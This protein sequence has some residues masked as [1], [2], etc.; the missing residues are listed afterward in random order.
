MTLVE[1]IPLSSALTGFFLGFMVL[2]AIFASRVWRKR[3]KA[4][5]QQSLPW[6]LGWT[7]GLSIAVLLVGI[8]TMMAGLFWHESRDRDGVLKSS[9]LSLITRPEG[10]SAISLTP[11][12]TVQK[13][14]VIAS[15]LT[16]EKAIEIDLLE[17]RRDRLVA[18]R[19]A[20]SKEA[21]IEEEIASQQMNALAEQFE[22]VSVSLSETSAMIAELVLQRGAIEQET[23]TLAA[24][25]DT[26]PAA[27][28]EGLLTVLDY[29]LAPAPEQV[30]DGTSEIAELDARIASLAAQREA[31]MTEVS[32]LAVQR[33]AQTEALV[34]SAKLSANT[35]S[36]TEEIADLAL[37]I[38][39]L[40][41]QIGVMQA[42]TIV[43]APHDGAILFR[44]DVPM[45]GPGNPLILALSQS[46]S[47]TTEAGTKNAISGFLACLT[48]PMNEIQ[49]L[50][51]SSEPVTFRVN[52]M[53]E[54]PF[55][56]ATYQHH[57][58][59]DG[60]AAAPLV[61]FAAAP[62]P[63]VIETLLRSGQPMSVSLVTVP[64][65]F[66]GP[67]FWTSLCLIA[68]A[69]G[70]FLL[71]GLVRVLVPAPE[72]QKD[73]QDQTST[74]QS[75]GKA[76]T[77]EIYELPRTYDP[78]PLRLTDR[79]QQKI[80]ALGNQFKV[81]LERGTLEPQLVASL[82]WM[83]D[84]YPQQAVEALTAV[85]GG[86]LVSLREALDL[87]ALEP[88]VARRARAIL[89]LV[90][91]ASLPEAYSK[92]VGLKEMPDPVLKPRLSATPKSPR[93]KV[94]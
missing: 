75:P 50:A 61:T 92:N 16:P 24:A 59:T 29:L 14:E 22:L 8:G 33:D 25:D 12:R 89:T 62:S 84:R 21:Q 82:E 73:E 76:A 74:Q 26:N 39:N 1:S 60:S 18:R 47:M 80:C 88:A 67:T 70:L 28:A 83:V 72:Q 53:V 90:R 5:K 36:R 48:L 77:T 65:P 30:E 41:A 3:N 57:E 6:L 44:N 40:T 54:T 86:S 4:Q 69:V 81:H 35:A 56:E 49:R 91:G 87:D 51:Q 85:L 93:P 45:L 7:R 27:Q 78:L 55:F 11:S 42:D 17:Q 52:G 71:Q 66:H 64:H 43:R 79:H 58:M 63:E 9:N 19:A 2:I 37:Q 15:Y 32:L 46:M 38:Q 23:E 31:L 94:M 34:A 13:G 68:I 10:V 20:L